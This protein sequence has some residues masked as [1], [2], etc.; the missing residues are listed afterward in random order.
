MTFFIFIRTL[1]VLTFSTPYGVNYP[2]P[3]P[4]RTLRALMLDA[5]IRGG[6]NNSYFRSNRWI[7]EVYGR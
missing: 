3:E 5:A 1:S 4:T 6:L 2:I 7:W